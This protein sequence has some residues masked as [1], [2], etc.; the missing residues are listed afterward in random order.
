[1]LFSSKNISFSTFQ[2]SFVS[3]K[4]ETEKLNYFGFFSN[5]LNFN[6]FFS[7]IFFLNSPI[8]LIEINHKSKKNNK[9]ITKY[10]NI[11]KYFILFQTGPKYHEHA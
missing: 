4:E 3:L 7:Y 1:M 8:P 6:G 9:K 5:N 10:K 2:F 11:L